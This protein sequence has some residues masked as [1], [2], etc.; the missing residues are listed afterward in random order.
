MH[1]GVIHTIRDRDQWDEVAGALDLSALPEGFE[2]LAT[3]TSQG[4]DR[5]LCLW[6]APS[7]EQLQRTLDD[8]LGGAAANDCFAMADDRVMLP[9]VNGQT[10]SV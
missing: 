9:A 4:V 3:G 1:V 7:V 6:R 2:L 10:A 5:A 8:V